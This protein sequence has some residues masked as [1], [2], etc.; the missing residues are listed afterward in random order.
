VFYITPVV[1]LETKSPTERFLNLDRIKADINEI[2][3]HPCLCWMIVNM[4]I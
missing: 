4:V 1:A 2:D 3:R